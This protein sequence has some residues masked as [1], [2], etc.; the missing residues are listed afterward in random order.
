LKEDENKIEM[1]LIDSSDIDPGYTL[2]ESGE[3]MEQFYAVNRHAKWLAFDSEFIPEKYYRNKLCLISAATPH[4]NYVI[5]AMKLKEMDWFIKLIE[6]PDILKISHAGENDYQILAAEFGARPRNLFDTQ[7]AYGFLNRDYPL[8]LQFLVEKELKTRLNKGELKSD[9]EMRPLRDEQLKYAV[10]DVIYLFPL[11][12]ELKAKLKKFGK[13]DWAMEENRRWEKNGFLNGG[14]V[15]I[16]DSLIGVMSR[17]FTFKQKVFLLRLHQWRV[18]EAKKRNVPLNY[19]LKTQFLNTI[20]KGI[21]AGKPLLLNDRTIPNSIVHQLWPMLEKMYCRRVTHSERKM[22]MQLPKDENGDPDVCI[23]MEMLYYVIKLKAA[24][25]GISPFLVTSRR[26]MSKM[27]TDKDYFP[28]ALDE[29]WRREL[30]GGDLLNWIKKKNAIDIA[31][32][33]NAC[34]LTMRNWEKT[35]ARMVASYRRML[36]GFSAVRT[37]IEDLLKRVTFTR[38]SSIGKQQAVMG[39]SEEKS[40]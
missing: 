5:D 25:C 33:D 12:K 8:G 37:K 21:A 1:K 29:G 36:K 15:D 19:V 13:L 14:S 31:F 2:L 30:L 35:P 10:R 3:Q 40:S 22:L 27:K 4:G 34:T 20:V 6:D 32:Q 38:N 9:W 23:A 11:M 39:V 17:N 24:E 26:E 28:P 7:L 18:V 16:V